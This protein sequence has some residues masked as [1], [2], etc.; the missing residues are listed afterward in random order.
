MAVARGVANVIRPVKMN[1]EIHGNT[2]PRLHMHL[3]P[4]APGDVYVGYV[5]HC[6]NVFTRTADDLELLRAAIHDSLGRR[7]T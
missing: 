5:N 4:R 6:R 3:F 1:Y 2:G 7:A